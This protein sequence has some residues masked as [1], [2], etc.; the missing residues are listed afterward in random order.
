MSIRLSFCIPTYNRADLIGATLRSIIDQAR[1]VEGVEI[2]VCD[3]AS[4]DATETV[5]RELAAGFPNL[6]YVRHPANLGADAN[7]M[8]VVEHARGQYCWLFGSDDTLREGALQEVLTAL[9]A[10]PAVLLSTRM[11]CDFHM[12]PQFVEPWLPSVTATRA[13]A[14][15]SD[16]DMQAYFAAAASLGAVFSFLSNIVVKRALWDE[17]PMRAEFMGT[18]YSHVYKIMGMLE[19]ETLVY[20]PDWTVYC[21]GGNDSFLEHGFLRR[22]LLDID[23]YTLLANTL[24]ARRPGPRAALLGILQRVYPFSSL[25]K[26]AAIGAD[27]GRW[28]DVR[29]RFLKAGFA[30]AQVERAGSIGAAWWFRPPVRKFLRFVNAQVKKWA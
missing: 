18:A 29:A 8:A 20:H 21:R 15:S 24:L 11:Q 17:V 5:V 4:T 9:A 26:I 22:V 10:S 2:V 3:N 16:A 30:P 19:N 25:V 13:Y 12:T 7:Y 28:P 1:L 14:W 27:E 23:G 6:M